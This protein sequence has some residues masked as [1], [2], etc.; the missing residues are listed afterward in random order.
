ME[1]NDELISQIPSEFVER[2]N[3]ENALKKLRR[4]AAYKAID[5]ERFYQNT[6]WVNEPSHSLTEWCV[7]IE[8][9]VNE[10]KHILS[11]MDTPDANEKVKHIMRK[12]AALAVCAMEEHGSLPR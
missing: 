4:E 5:S 7:F 8:D 3:T 1:N 10:A 9:Y 11:R 6:R 12:V 2:V